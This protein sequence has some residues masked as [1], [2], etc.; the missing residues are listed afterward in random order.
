VLVNGAGGG[1]GTFAVQIARALGAH[2]T[3]V[4]NARSLDLVRSLGAERVLDYGREDFTAAADRYDLILDFSGNHPLSAYR[5]VLLP[6]G[7]YVFG[8]DTSRGD[9]LGPLAGF[10]KVVVTAKFSSQ[11]LTVFFANMNQADLAILGDMLH[12]GAVKPVIDRSYPLARLAEAIRYQ[13]TEHARGK[14]VVTVD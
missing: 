5:R 8:G 12:S 11:K 1:V 14:V 7:V 9:W 2:V 10:A 13:E 6:H 3:A 4:T